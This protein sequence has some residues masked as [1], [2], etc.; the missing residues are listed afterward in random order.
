MAVKK[1]ST[2]LLYIIT[3]T[4]QKAESLVYLE[5]MSHVAKKNFTVVGLFKI[6]FNY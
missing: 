1:N 3:L 2:L 5:M 6:A 4:M